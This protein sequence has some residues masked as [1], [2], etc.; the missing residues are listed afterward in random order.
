MTSTTSSG[1]NGS[2]SSLQES[3]PITKI[4]GNV[5]RYSIGFGNS[6]KDKEAFK[7]PAIF[8]E[9]LAADHIMS[10]SNEGDL[11]FDCFSGS[12]T[13]LKQAHLLNR[14]WVGAEISAKYCEIAK[15]RIEPIVN[16]MRF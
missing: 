6:T 11:I 10:W 4:K 8:P 7:H 15:Q 3:S 13:T 5:W 9:K 12:G 16:Q 1:V 14:K 2:G